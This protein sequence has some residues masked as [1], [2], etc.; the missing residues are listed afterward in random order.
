LKKKKYE[1][2]VRH[3]FLASGGKQLKC[4]F[5]QS[6]KDFALVVEKKMVNGGIFRNS[7]DNTWNIRDLFLNIGLAVELNG[8]Y[9]LQSWV[10]NLL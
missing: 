5:I 1:L 2:Y 8:R 4:G 3:V 7:L 10:G 6:K 9:E